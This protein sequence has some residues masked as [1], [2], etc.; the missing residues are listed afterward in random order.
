MEGGEKM[1]VSEAITQ[2]QARTGQALEDSY[3]EIDNGA[4]LL[5]WLSELDGRIAYDLYRA[6][7]WKMYTEDDLSYTL[8]IIFPWDTLY[9]VYL[10]AMIYFANGEYDRYANAQAIYQEQISTYRK[11]VQRSRGG[12][13]A[14]T[15]PI[16]GTGTGGTGTE[17]TMRSTVS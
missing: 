5:R 6:A 2:A 11:T 3:S 16:G 1:T 9:P 13:G 12:D 14:P 4:L 17:I 7:T 15:L 10:E 8:A